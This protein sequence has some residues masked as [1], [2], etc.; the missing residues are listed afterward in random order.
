MK[1]MMLLILLAMGSV[2]VISNQSDTD[3]ASGQEKRDPQA[4]YRLRW[5]QS[6]STPF[7][8]TD[9]DDKID[10]F[11]NCPQIFNPKQEDRDLDGVGDICDATCEV[12]YPQ[13]DYCH[14]KTVQTVQWWDK[15]E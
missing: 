11:D 3:V 6:R 12:A 2:F 15:G 8:D 10:A 13:H 14:V 1:K 9:T 5:E 7:P 4:L